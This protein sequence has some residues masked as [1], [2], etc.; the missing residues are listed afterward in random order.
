[1]KIRNLEEIYFKGSGSSDQADAKGIVGN[2]HTLYNNG[3]GN[4]TASME[5]SVEDKTCDSL[6]L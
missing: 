3:E 1:M 4:I 6:K 2:K 5:N